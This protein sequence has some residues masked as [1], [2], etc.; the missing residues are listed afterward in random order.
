MK[1]ADLNL[2]ELVEF[3][4]GRVALHG[5]RLILHDVQALGLFRKDLI[6]MLGDEQAQRI[7]TRKGYFWGQTDAAMMQHMF[8]WDSPQEWLKAAEML[9]KIDGWAEAEM[10]IRHLD[11]ALGKIEIEMLWRNSTEVEQHI[12][13][14]GRSPYPICWALVGYASG[15]AT[16][17]LG[18]PVYFV[19]MQCQAAGSP[20]CIGRGKDQESWGPEIEPYLSF[21]QAA[22]LQKKVLELSDQINRQQ[23]ELVRHR[24]ELAAQASQPGLMPV[25]VRSP[26]FLR[27]LELATR[28]SKFDTTV[29]ITGETGSGKEILAR[30]IHQNSSRA[31]RP[32]L[33]INCSALPETLLESEL[34]GFRAGAFTGATRNHAGLFEE[35]SGGTLFLDEIGDITPAMQ[36]KLLRV[37]QEREI[38][39]VGESHSRPVDVRVIS[40]TNQNLEKLVAEGR[41]REDL[42]YRLHVVNIR[43]PPLR[44]RRDDI[45]PLARYFLKNCS[46]RLHLQDLRMAPA[47]VDLLLNYP[48]PGNVRELENA[49]EHAAVM[50]GGKVIAPDILPIAKTQAAVEVR[51]A[52]PYRSLAEIETD[53]IRQVLKLTGGNRSETARILKIGEA[54]LYRKLKQMED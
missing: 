28:V 18:K 49:I 44:E 33:A 20:C 8:H 1:A 4:Q 5:R 7:L 25:E 13:I 34:F 24:Q 50:C 19:E 46:S 52:S 31:N 48:W 17:C 39:R 54:T 41:F 35:A 10:Q 21:F 9:L 37:L 40:A 30:Y 43:I 11:V 15:Y 23:D 29:L 45:L 32:M 12:T 36:V 42:F 51:S 27:T 26:V 53:H 47:C 38:R 22:D 3:S 6:E 16:Y 14:L 2:A